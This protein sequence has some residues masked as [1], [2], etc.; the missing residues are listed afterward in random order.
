MR[1]HL[2]FVYVITKTDVDWTKLPYSFLC[3]YLEKYLYSLINGLKQKQF[4]LDT[5]HKTSLNI[6]NV[7]NKSFKNTDGKLYIDSGGYSIIV[8]DIHPNQISKFLYCY[9]YFLEKYCETS[10]DYLFSLDI[11]IFLKYPKYNTYNILYDLNKKSLTQSF[12]IIQNNPILYNKFIMVWQFKIYTQY[13]IWNRIYS[14]LPKDITKNIRNYALGGM[15]GLRG[16]TGIQ[17]SPFISMV[18][19]LLYLLF[20]NNIENGVIHLLGV[21]G[22]HDRFLGNFL[23]KLFNDYYKIPVTIS[24]DTINYKVSGFNKSSLIVTFDRN[25]NL[26]SIM[27]IGKDDI[28]YLCCHCNS[29]TEEIAKHVFHLQRTKSCLNTEI[30]A[31]LH[32]AYERICDFIIEDIVERENLADIFVKSKNFNKFKNI[33]KSI[34]SKYYKFPFIINY[35]NKILLNFQY[36]YVFHNW[37]INKRDISEFERLNRKF[38]DL[39][40]F[41]FKIV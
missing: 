8:G 2:E 13:E 21:Y 30:P 39:I 6:H 20:T 17:F 3:I 10:C 5:I 9:N 1:H 4:G 25:D 38:I 14:E 32:V 12:N 19:K 31:L 22:R 36:L 15:V 7:Y 27:D 35:L 33:A 40:N 24:Y 37:W 28:E 34:L 23:A 41:P 18:Y 26:I 16:I 29:V 11:P